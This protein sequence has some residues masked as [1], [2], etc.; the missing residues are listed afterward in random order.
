MTAKKVFVL[1]TSALFAFMQNEPGA[2]RMEQ[3]LRSARQRGCTVYVSFISLAELYY[4]S[5][6]EAGRSAAL[7]M[8]VHVKA[9]PLSVVE[10]TERL[11]LLAGSIKANHHCSLAD[12]FIAATA[13]QV[14][15]TLVHKDPEIEQ[16]NGIISTEKLPYKTS[17]R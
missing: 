9:L 2:D 10:S 1:D 6:Q 7:E 4:V 14:G 16:V 8:I 3:I 13:L 11:T 5:W 17:T 15:G 12:A